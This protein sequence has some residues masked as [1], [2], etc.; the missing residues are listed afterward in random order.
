MHIDPVK[1][2]FNG[3]AIL[4]KIISAHCECGISC[5]LHIS[6]IFFLV[7]DEK[8][9]KITGRQF[10]K[11]V[12]IKVDFDGSTLTLNAQGMESIQA[13][14]LENGEIVHTEVFGNKCQG[15]DLGPEIGAWIANH[16][17]KP[18]LKLKLLY[19]DYSN[20]TST[21]QLQVRIHIRNDYVE[22]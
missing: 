12:T 16:L 5:H 11:L 20:K 6:I 9:R 19:H 7:V 15:T 22:S 3:F 4:S 18:H 17:E 2:S 8:N 14:I 10:P 1:A 13:Q 21:R